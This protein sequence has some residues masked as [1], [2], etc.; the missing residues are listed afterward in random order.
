[1][2]GSGADELDE[3]AWP[4]AGARMSREANLAGRPIYYRR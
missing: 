4:L 2:M 1:M 3:L